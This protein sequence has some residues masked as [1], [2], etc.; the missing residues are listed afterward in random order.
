MSHCRALFLSRLKCRKATHLSLYLSLLSIFSR[1]KNPRITLGF[2]HKNFI[3][4]SLTFLGQV[5]GLYTSFFSPDTDN[6]N[7]ATC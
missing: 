5:F 4:V 6:R 7:Y 2:E 1:L 3:P